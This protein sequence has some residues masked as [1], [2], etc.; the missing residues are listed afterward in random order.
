MQEHVFVH[1]PSSPEVTEGLQNM[2]I[3][4]SIVR[5]FLPNVCAKVFYM[6]ITASPNPLFTMSI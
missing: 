4:R 6:Q 1:V 5:S 3:K 2:Q